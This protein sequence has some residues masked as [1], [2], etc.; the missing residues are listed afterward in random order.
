[1]ILSGFP[2]AT[3]ARAFETTAFPALDF[4]A[5]FAPPVTTLA[6]RTAGTTLAMARPTAP[7]FLRLSFVFCFML[8]I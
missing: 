7:A 5:T 1:M 2:F 6:R 3:F 8:I 4:D